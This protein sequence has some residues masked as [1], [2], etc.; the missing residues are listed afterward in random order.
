[1]ED[2]ATAFPLCGIDFASSPHEGAHRWH[3]LLNG[4]DAMQQIATCADASS[5]I[6]IT[7]P[8]VD[9]D[10]PVIQ[11]GGRVQTSRTIT[12]QAFDPSGIAE[13]AMYGIVDA[14]GYEEFD[15]EKAAS[16]TFEVPSAVNVLEI[17]AVDCAD[18]SAT[19]VVVAV[20]A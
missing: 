16:S 8:D 2:S 6:V 10:G 5:D 17:T 20:A 19:T 11:C 4:R 3:V 9:V 18:N 13:I 1:V 12:C 14:G 15:C 7:P